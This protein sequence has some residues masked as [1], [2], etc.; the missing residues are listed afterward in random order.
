MAT[1]GYRSRESHFR[2]TQQARQAQLANLKRGRQPGKKI[3]AALRRKHERVL[4]GVDIVTFA[5]EH[6]GVTLRPV[7]RLILKAVYG[8]SLTTDE[9]DIY[10]QITGGLDFRHNADR[11]AVEAVLALGARSG[12]SLMTSIMALYEAIVRGHVWRKHLAK[13]EAG[14]A[15]SRSRLAERNLILPIVAL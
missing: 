1:R 8:L 7:Q 14:Y 13:N 10:Q 3:T 11:E 5:E 6:L 15:M 9:T 2:K 12:K 4:Q